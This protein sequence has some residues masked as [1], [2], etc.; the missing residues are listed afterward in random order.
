MPNNC[1]QDGGFIGSSGCT[2]PN[3]NH[4]EL[5]KGLLAEKTPRMISAADCDAALKEGFFVDGAN[6][7]RMGFGKDLLEHIESDVNHSP[8]DIIAR[9]ERLLFAMHTVTN[10]DKTEENHRQIPGRT[11]YTKAFKDFGIL[12]VTDT[13]TGAVDKVFTYFPRRDGKKRFA[14]PSKT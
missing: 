1:P 8:D 13:E 7:K 4:S 12:A 9:K 2:H 11:L 6:G 3:H 5:V 14:A 10:P